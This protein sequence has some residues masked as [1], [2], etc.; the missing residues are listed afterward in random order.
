MLELEMAEEE[1]NSRSVGKNLLNTLLIVVF[2]KSSCCQGILNQLE[3][4]F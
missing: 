3:C 1:M 2:L 4:C